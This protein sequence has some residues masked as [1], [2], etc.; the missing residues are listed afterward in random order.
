MIQTHTRGLLIFTSMVCLVT[1]ASIASVM[2]QTTTPTP[3]PT[4]P[5][6][7]IASNGAAYLKGTLVAIG[8]NALTVRSWSKDWELLPSGTIKYY[9]SNGLLS[10]LAEFQVNDYL[11]IRGIAAADGSI[12]T[13]TIK[14]LSITAGWGYVYGTLGSLSTNSFNVVTTRGTQYV[15]FNSAT[16]ITFNGLPSSAANLRN[17]MLVGVSGI[18][19]RPKLI[20]TAKTIAS[21]NPPVTVS[22]APSK[23][24]LN[25]GGAQQFTATVGGIS[26]TQVTWLVKGIVGGDAIVGTITPSG[27]YVAPASISGYL[28][29]TISAKSVADPTKIGSATVTIAP[30]DH[31]PVGWHD[32]SD[33]SVTVGWVCD[34]NSFANALSV[35][36]YKDGARGVGGVL[37]GTAYANIAREAAVG[38]SCGNNV[39]HGFKF[40]T[41]S[42]LKDGKTH[43]VYVYAVNIG[44]SG[45]TRTLLSG[46]PKTVQCAN[47]PAPPPPAPA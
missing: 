31:T 26:G 46:T 8:Q 2:A 16:V 25:P 36:L 45:S 34:A 43:T 4:P 20:L 40:T 5:T 23:V 13:Q 47:P 37:L 28:Y 41:P 29:V 19:D 18:W 9:R 11:E 39:N 15:I 44:S 1:V 17:G 21:R 22:V 3:N 27:L 12:A 14:N 42:T 35:E 32:G 10:S 38:A 33:C 24:A 30:T 7:N 6:L